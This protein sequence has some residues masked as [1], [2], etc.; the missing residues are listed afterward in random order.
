MESNWQH[1]QVT[2]GLFEVTKT[3]GQTLANIWQIVW[4]IWT[5]RINIIA[6]VKGEG[7]NLNVNFQD[8]CFGHGFKKPYEYAKIDENVYK[9]LRFVSIKST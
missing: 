7:S 4:S 1:K 8:T 9:N 6:H 3:I 2:I 5:L